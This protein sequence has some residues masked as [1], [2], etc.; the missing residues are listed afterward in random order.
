MNAPGGSR[1]W[2]PFRSCTGYQSLDVVIRSTTGK[3]RVPALSFKIDYL[4]L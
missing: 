1:M 3:T 2:D 4:R